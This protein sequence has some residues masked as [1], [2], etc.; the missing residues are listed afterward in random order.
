MLS[1][2]QTAR[3]RV[4]AASEG[5]GVDLLNPVTSERI[6]ENRIVNTYGRTPWLVI[7]SMEQC[8][9][10]HSW[11]VKCASIFEALSPHNPGCAPVGLTIEQEI[12]FVPQEGGT[13]EIQ[14]SS[15]GV[16]GCPEK[17]DSISFSLVHADTGVAV[18]EYSVVDDC[19]PGAR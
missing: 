1:R 6:N 18:Q 15:P 5:R 4:V 14:V 17:R 12:C 7:S 11:P 16:V 19:E 3:I 8:L 10:A 13:Y 9:V 2:D